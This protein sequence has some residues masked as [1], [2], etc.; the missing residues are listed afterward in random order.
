VFFHFSP[1]VRVCMREEKRA[2]LG[3]VQNIFFV[4]AP[5]E[6]APVEQGM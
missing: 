2:P 5:E 1:Y 6:A 4:G 3:E